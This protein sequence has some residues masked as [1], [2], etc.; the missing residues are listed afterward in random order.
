ME[1]LHINSLVYMYSFYH[2]V[3]HVSNNTASYVCLLPFITSIFLAKATPRGLIPW[4]E[5]R[6]KE[7]PIKAAAVGQ[8]PQI[9]KE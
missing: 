6:K 7:T 4:E 1:F 2:S 3:R 9:S 5:E 8:N